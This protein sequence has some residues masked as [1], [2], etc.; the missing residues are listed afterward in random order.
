MDDSRVEL[1]SVYVCVCTKI[2]RGSHVVRILF[3]MSV[4]AHLIKIHV[5]N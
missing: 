1:V 5:M 3:R 4:R 2:K